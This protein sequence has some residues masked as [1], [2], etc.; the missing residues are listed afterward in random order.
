MYEISSFFRPK[1]K[2]KRGMN[3]IRNVYIKGIHAE[4]KEMRMS[5]FANNVENSP[6][7][8]EFLFILKETLFIETFEKT[9]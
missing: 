6:T 1:V 7:S 8:L 2:R 5:W 9:W 3:I 4:C